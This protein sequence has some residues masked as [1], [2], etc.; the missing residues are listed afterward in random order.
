[1]INEINYY[2]SSICV[3]LS[4]EQNLVIDLDEYYIILINYK[5]SDFYKD[6]IDLS[7]SSFI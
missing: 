7:L 3:V 6:I 2:T 5:A 4:L 1:M